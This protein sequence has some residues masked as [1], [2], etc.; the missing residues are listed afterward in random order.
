MCAFKQIAFADDRAVP[1]LFVPSMG[2]GAVLVYVGTNERPEIAVAVRAPR[3]LELK[4]DGRVDV[5]LCPVETDELRRWVEED[6][7]RVDVLGE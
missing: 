4:I 7:I 3:V 1:W 2:V 6:N 5:S